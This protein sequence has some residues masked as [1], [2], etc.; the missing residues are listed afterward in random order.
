MSDNSTIEVFQ[1]LYL[2]GPDSLRPALRIAILELASLPWRHVPEKEEN[3][4]T[5]SGGDGDVIVFERDATPGLPGA[6]LVLWSTHDG[7]QVVNIVPIEVGSLGFTAYN[8]ILDDFVLRIGK[9]AAKRAGFKLETTAPYQTIK[10]WLSPP[11]ANALRIFSAA[12]N[13]STGAS[14]PLDK[15]R[16]LAFLIEAHRDKNS[17]DA[18]RLARWLI[19]TEHWPDD[20]AHELAIEY[21]LALDL[22]Q[23]YDQSR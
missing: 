17:L 23:Q 20:T 13:K 15:K 1:D 11:A 2:R 6:G 4:S 9:Q 5:Y 14:H 8:A 3:L 21:E 10:D 18:G 19:E 12:A 7:Y 16:W 22:L